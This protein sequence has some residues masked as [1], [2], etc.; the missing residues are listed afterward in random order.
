MNDW[1]S[2]TSSW[3]D[4]RK[5]LDAESF[6]WWFVDL[7]GYGRSRAI[8]GEYTVREAAA[9][10]LALGDALELQRFDVVGHSMSTLIALHLAQR[11]ADRLR[12][13][14]VLTPPPPAGF[15][16]DPGMLAAIEALARAGD[17]QRS[18]WLRMR[19]GDQAPE[20]WVRFK[21]AQWRAAAEPEAVA[22]YAAMFARDGLP[23][24]L[25]KI[26]IPVLA[27]T[28]ER[29]DEIMRRD[30]IRGL[31]S[32]LADELVV[33]EISGC[34]HYPMQETPVQLTAALEQFLRGIEPSCA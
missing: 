33:H 24:P 10:L 12:S 9:D 15:G 27:V 22:A 31:L 25:A 21:A 34:G 5:Y 23:D 4:A 13:V 29:D 14:S 11:H 3:S 7:R 30:S 19:F 28:G 1:M 20:G 16:A 32:P 18:Y 2:D 6:S 26:Q 8:A 17:D